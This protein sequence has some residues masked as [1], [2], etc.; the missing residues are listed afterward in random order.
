MYVERRIASGTAE[1]LLMNSLI[2]KE[3]T[4]RTPCGTFD[5][6]GGRVR[7]FVILR[8]LQNKMASLE[9]NTLTQ[10]EHDSTNLPS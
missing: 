7:S 2:L 8:F 4:E 3:V 6:W 9:K 5:P 1:Y 10:K